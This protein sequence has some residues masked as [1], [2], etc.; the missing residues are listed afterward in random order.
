MVFRAS[1]MPADPAAIPQLPPRRTRRCVH[2]ESASQAEYAGSIPVIGSSLTRAD[3][4]LRFARYGGRSRNGP[5]SPGA[6]CGAARRQ[7]N[8]GATN[9]CTIWCSTSL[10]PIGQTASD[11]TTRTIHWAACGSSSVM[12]VSSAARRPNTGDEGSRQITTGAQ[13]HHHL[14]HRVRSNLFQCHRDRLYHSLRATQ[15]FHGAPN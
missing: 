12:P 1:L 5:V 6:I 14:A 3:A 8:A 4:T 11:M 15:A 9:R 13:P 2:R 10:S 7:L